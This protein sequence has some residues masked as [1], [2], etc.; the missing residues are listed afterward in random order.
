MTPTHPRSRLLAALLIGGGLFLLAANFGLLGWVAS[1]LW[2]VLFLVCGT[3]FLIAYRDDRARWWALLPGFGLLALGAAVLAPENAGGGLFLGLVGAGFAAVYLT[4]RRR[5]WAVLPAGALLTLALV[6][7]LDASR[8]GFDAGWLFFLGLAATFGLL[9]WLPEGEG[10]QRWALFPALGA[11]GLA[12]LT[13]AASGIGT[14]LF[15]LLL[16]ALGTLLL[17]RQRRPPRP[18]SGPKGV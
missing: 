6:A 13:V 12:A 14:T 8:P 7:W 16:I 1:W 15:P 17:W 4:D 9:F 2:A 3:A 10:K 5:W 18:S 11:L